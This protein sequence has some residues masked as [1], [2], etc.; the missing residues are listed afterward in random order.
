MWAKLLMKKI[1]SNGFFL[2]PR[3]PIVKCSRFEWS[4]GIYILGP[5]ATEG[6]PLSQRSQEEINFT[7]HTRDDGEFCP[8]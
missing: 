4:P 3:V 6:S 1:P 7:L 2:C 8:S 5:P